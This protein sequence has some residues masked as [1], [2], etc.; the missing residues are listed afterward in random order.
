MNALLLE[1]FE[2]PAN[3]KLEFQIIDMAPKANL[4]VMKAG[5]KIATNKDKSIILVEKKPAGEYKYEWI[6]CR[7][8]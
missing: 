5:K 4:K 2:R 3:A 7:V 8:S 6:C 1:I